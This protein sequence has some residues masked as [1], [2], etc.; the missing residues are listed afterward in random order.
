MCAYRGVFTHVIGY[1]W[2][3]CV[4]MRVHVCA[5]MCT[6]WDRSKRRTCQLGEQLEAQWEDGG[7]TLR[8]LLH[9]CTVPLEKCVRKRDAHSLQQSLCC[10]HVWFPLLQRAV[11]FLSWFCSL[12][13][14]FR[15]VEVICGTLVMLVSYCSFLTQS[16][17]FLYN[18]WY[19]NKVRL[20]TFQ[21]F[22]LMLWSLRLHL[23]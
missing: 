3:L 16:G 2:C 9:A 15:G 7:I 6:C 10:L 23:F 21:K 17:F 14:L 13:L 22:G 18:H 19:I 12:S 5:C 8:L 4:L 1:L 11:Q 20:Y